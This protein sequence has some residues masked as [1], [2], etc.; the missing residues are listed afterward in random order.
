MSL[1]ETSGSG[2]STENN[3]DAETS[4]GDSAAGYRLVSVSSLRNS[5]EAL[6]CPTCHCHRLELQES[7]VGAH[8]TFSVVCPNGSLSFRRNSFCGINFVGNFLWTHV[9]WTHIFWT[10]VSSTETFTDTRYKNCTLWGIF[11]RMIHWSAR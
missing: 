5:I 7:G 6:L 3:K 9:L 10:H 11:S 1:L 2:E 4:L 8:P